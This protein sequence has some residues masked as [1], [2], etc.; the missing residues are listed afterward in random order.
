MK[1]KKLVPALVFILFVFSNCNKDEFKPTCETTAEQAL[2]EYLNTPGLQTN[3][4]QLAGSALGDPR[5][6][7]RTYVS[8]LN[9]NLIEK[10]WNIAV[11]T[12]AN[13]KHTDFPGTYHYTVLCQYKIHHFTGY[14]WGVPG[15]PNKKAEIIVVESLTNRGDMDGRV[16]SCPDVC[17]DAIAVIRIEGQSELKLTKYASEWNGGTPSNCVQVSLWDEDR[18]YFGFK[19][20]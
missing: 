4:V 7:I 20:Y 5:A 11:P 10:S 3:Y 17:K 16:G 6:E 19:V 1:L 12:T 2:S 15:T 13:P 9:S 14:T 8:K 18:S